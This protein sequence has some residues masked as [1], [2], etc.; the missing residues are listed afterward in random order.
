MHLKIFDTVK[1]CGIFFGTN[2]QNRNED[3]LKTSILKTADN[4]KN[5][6]LT[7]R[8]K[9]ILINALLLAKLWFI[10]TIIIPSP[11]FLPW[12]RGVIFSIVWKSNEKIARQTVFLSPKD[13]GIGLIN[14]ELK[15]KALWLKHIHKAILAP[16]NAL[17]LTKYWCAIK[18]TKYNQN[19]WSNNLPHNSDTK[20]IPTFYKVIL[21]LVQNFYSTLKDQNLS[22]FTRLAYET[23]LNSQNHIPIIAQ[24]RTIT[25]MKTIWSSLYSAD[26]SSEVRELWWQ[27][28]HQIINTNVRLHRFK[29]V[30]SNPCEICHKA[31]ESV[32]HCFFSVP[33]TLQLYKN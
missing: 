30:E 16:E 28:S 10:G 24:K 18:L 19:V 7:H 15:L 33:L 6:Y 26:L 1:I 8:G 29:L 12:L 5:R 4:I 17:D 14:P 21:K 25:L 2:A 9:A 22:N 20:Q 23:I 13:G 3:N 31:P 11:N 27:I 32:I